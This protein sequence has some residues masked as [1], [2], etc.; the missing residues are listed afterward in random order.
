MRFR[1]DDADINVDESIKT[2]NSVGNLLRM[3]GEDIR[4]AKSVLERAQENDLPEVKNLLSVVSLIYNEHQA[5]VMHHGDGTDRC[6]CELCK[7]WVSLRQAKEKRLVDSIL[8][9]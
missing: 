9:K 6:D 5:R 7:A 3:L 2:L 1:I 8:G 4:D